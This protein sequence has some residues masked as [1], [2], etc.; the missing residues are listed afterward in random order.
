MESAREWRP[1]TLGSRMGA[2]AIDWAALVFSS[3]AIF[4]ILIYAVGLRGTS[5]LVA[6]FACQLAAMAGCW[7]RGRSP[8]IAA[9]GFRMTRRRDGRAPGLR[10]A[11]ARTVIVF[12]GG[13]SVVALGLIVFS[14]GAGHYPSGAEPA[15]SYTRIGILVVLAAT[16]LGAATAAMRGDR[17]PLYDR[18]LQLDVLELQAVR[19]ARVATNTPRAIR[20]PVSRKRLSSWWLALPAMVAL[21]DALCMLS[22]GM[23]VSEGLWGASVVIVVLFIGLPSWIGFEVLRRVPIR[24]HLDR[25]GAPG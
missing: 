13:S 25:S 2:A 11:I 16:Y 15:Y 24:E 22:L 9:L 5:C 12:P 8:G 10:R 18:W 17:R 14:M 6:G 3:Y 1:P 19:P 7:S 23:T 20:P 21:W 4:P